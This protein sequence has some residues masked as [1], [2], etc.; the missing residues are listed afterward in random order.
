[1]RRQSEDTL[2]V[3]LVHRPKYDDWTFPKGKLE[4]GESL[5]DCALREVEE[6]TGL[7]CT[8]GREILGTVYVDRHGRTKTVHYWVMWVESGE[9][10]PNREVDEL[11]W[12]P[13]DRAARRLTYPRDVEVLQS[14]G[15]LRGG[16]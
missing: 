8:L 10:T 3:L 1:M 5:V 13:P 2:E 11:C 7:R 15:D 14:V 4:P 9:F 12:L 6:E 16:G